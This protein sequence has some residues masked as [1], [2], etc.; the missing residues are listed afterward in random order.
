M[1]LIFI[2]ARA[3]VLIAGLLVR[4]LLVLEG[5]PKVAEELHSEEA[6]KANEE[7]EADVVIHGRHR[8][9]GDRVELRLQAAV[10]LELEE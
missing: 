1:S 3:Q 4:F 7:E 8:P 9:E 5:N 2:Q 6:V 10:R